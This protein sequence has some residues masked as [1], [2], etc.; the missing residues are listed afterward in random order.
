MY[1]YN[2]AR[3]LIF[4]SR[5]YLPHYKESVLNDEKKLIGEFGFRRR[6]CEL[7]IPFSHLSISF[8]SFAVDP[9]CQTCI[10]TTT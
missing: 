7:C 3:I 10:Q 2:F 9:G 8:E 6:Y 5:S 1:D 4:S